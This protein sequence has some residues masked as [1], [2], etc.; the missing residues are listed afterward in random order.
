MNPDIW[1]VHGRSIRTKRSN[2]T[3]RMK[4]LAIVISLD[5]FR[6]HHP[7]TKVAAEQLICLSIE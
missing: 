1:A 3:E 4:K 5:N 7:K 2:G 6:A